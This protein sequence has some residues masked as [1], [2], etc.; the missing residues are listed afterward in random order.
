VA[1]DWS[2]RPDDAK[3]V[4]VGVK[5]YTPD[6]LPCQ[7]RLL[8]EFFL[9]GDSVGKRPVTICPGWIMEHFPDLLPEEAEA[10]FLE[11]FNAIPNL[12]PAV[13]T[14]ISAKVPKAAYKAMW[15]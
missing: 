15:K 4:E 10:K 5:E 7:V 9:D 11:F 1:L 3:I 6:G 8:A 13:L 14:A 2:V 12:P